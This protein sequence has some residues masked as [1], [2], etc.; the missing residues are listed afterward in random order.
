MR[1]LSCALPVFWLGAAAALE[2]HA[3]TRKHEAGRCALRGHCGAQ[4]FFGSDLPCPYN[5]L[6]VEPD[7]RIR[8]KLVD[9][10]GAKWRSGPICCGEDQVSWIQSKDITYPMRLIRVQ[11]DALRS[12][13][14]RA[15]SLIS[16]CPA[17][18]EN[19][20]DTF[21]TLTCSPDQSLFVNVTDI[22]QSRA[23]KDVA[24][25]LDYVVSK[26]YGSGFYNSCKDVKF[27]ATNGYV[28]DFIGGGAKNYTA[29]LKFLG[30]KKPFGSP[31]QIDFPRPNRVSE[32]MEAMD[33]VPKRCNDTDVLYRCACVD[34]PSACPAL[35]A[36]HKARSCHVGVLPCLSFAV[37]L[38]YSLLLLLFVAGVAFHVLW[39]NYSQR[40]S[41]R[42]RLLQDDT[43]SDEDDEDDGHIV[44][45]AGYVA[46]T[47]KHYAPNNIL[48]RYF[49]WLGR[50]CARYPG[51]V[52]GSSILVAA[53]LSLGWINFAVETSVVRLWISPTSAAA[54][55]KAFFDD[56]F[57]PFY[58]IEQAIL[59]RETADGP[60]P[61]L[62]YETLEWWFDVHSRV[63]RLRSS[64]EGITLDNVCFK[65]T[66]DACVVES[67]VSYF[68][69][70]FSALNPKRW[71]P[72]LRRCAEYPI[73]C[74]P[75]FQK[76]IKK[77]MVFG[78]WKKSGNVIDAK[79]LIATWVINNHAEG[80]YEE[81]RAMAWES[82]LKELLLDVQNEAMERGLHLSFS[83]EISLEQELNKSS[84]TDAKIVII[85]Y[86]IMFLYASLALGSTTAAI[87]SL[88][89][90]PASLLVQSKFTLGIFGI[91]IVLMSVSAS[92]GLFSALGIKVTLIIAEVI[93]FLVLAIG[94]DN[95]FLIVHEFER[96]NSSYPDYKMEDRVSKALGRIGPS[97]LLSATTETVSTLR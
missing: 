34:C 54:E 11:L 40:R 58:R 92:V 38:I 85:S 82:A 80:S 57:G 86:I 3:W 74:L 84:N 5:G 39:M 7:D 87:R 48:D 8:Q 4:S 51:I 69:D 9:V 42:V 1:L 50:M 43:L 19:F 62:S 73:E 36:L 76:P 16:A 60:V 37:I 72:Q 52:I 29:F 96:V 22:Q 14:K 20:F 35:P 17:C 53:V 21:C 93:P 55:E 18:K 70:G 32:P 23:K 10:C 33:N 15:E 26:R 59:T 63:E 95:I 25:E 65:P 24:A 30:D 75:A 68:P 78:G 89:S 27:S 31:F 44:A 94:V 49:G 56:K 88:S 77:E 83:T 61:V 41:E 45:N 67:L 90:N 66:G 47:E 71:Q 28:M 12:N 13:L 81:Q 46:P 91:I 64:D 6:A 79:A 97:I 2:D